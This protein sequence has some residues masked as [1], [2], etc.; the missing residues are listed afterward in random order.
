MSVGL[1]LIVTIFLFL[2]T[3]K[4]PYIILPLPPKFKIFMFALIQGI[5]AWLILSI[6][7]MLPLV[8]YIVGFVIIWSFTRVLF[9]DILHF[10]RMQGLVFFVL[11]VAPLLFSGIGLWTSGLTNAERFNS[12]VTYKSGMIYNNTIPD[13][14]VRLITPEYATNIAQ[15]HLS[16]YGSNVFVNSAHIMVYNGRLSWAC[17]IVSTNT[18]SENYVKGFLIIDAN[19]PTRDPI[20]INR[21]MPIGEGLFWDHDIFFRNY[22]ADTSILYEQAYVEVDNLGHLAYILTRTRLNFDLTEDPLGP[23]VYFENGTIK[24]YNSIDNVPEFIERI[25][26]EPF[27]E[28]DISRWGDYRRGDGFDLFAGG[29]LWI[30]PPSRERVE[31][32]EDLRYILD[33]DTN[34]IDAIVAV[35]PVSSEKTLAGVFKISRNHV[36][37]YDYKDLNLISGITAMD[38]VE[39]ELPKP[40]TGF[41]YAAM[42]MLYPVEIAPG[43]FKLTWYVPVYWQEYSSEESTSIT[44]RL[45]GLALVDASKSDNRIL[46]LATG[47]LTGENL[48]RSARLKYIALFGGTQIQETINLIANIT[49]YYSYVQNGVTHIVLQTNNDTY[50]YIE[51]WPGSMP[52]QD[53]YALLSAQVGNKFNATIDVSGEQ[54]VITAFKI[55]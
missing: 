50:K 27:L 40:A 5:T 24:E 36:Y 33:P 30:I 47:G 26:A 29:L 20:E 32:S 16:S 12:F 18:L 37:Y 3:P 21:T 39:S 49:G 41:Y 17:E 4:K 35:H 15:Q 51:G 11:I 1:L 31:I 52:L 2:L 48:V 6:F 19:D 45:A 23:I 46:E 38:V 25:F 13:N 43:D 34:E 55:I 22:L 10:K 9:T 7:L 28:R 44:I 8:W 42:P 53:W 14:M 54:Y